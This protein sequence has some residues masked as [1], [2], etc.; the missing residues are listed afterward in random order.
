MRIFF[1]VVA[2]L[3]LGCGSS[4]AQMSTVG[5]TAM[6]LPTTPGAIV[7]S[8]FAG[9]SPF[10]SLFSAATV[11]GAPATTLAAP[12]L[13]D[14]PTLPGTSV[15]CSPATQELSP[16]V[17]SVNSTTTAVTASPATTLNS[18]A[19]PLMP[20][21]MTA[22][23]SSSTTAPILLP[24]AMPVAILGSVRGSS[25]GTI[26]TASSPG[27]FASGGSCTSAPGNALASAS[28]LAPTTPDIPAIPPA[29]A[30]QSP[31][32]DIGSTSISQAAMV[33]PTPNSAACNEAVSMNLANPT[34][35]APVNA[36]AAAPPAGA[37]Q[38]P[39]C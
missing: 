26:T 19:A 37:P 10:T 16:S 27:D 24:P 22:P 4:F 35:M 18:T 39:G 33:M 13:A 2:M 15:N 30:I 1:L 5:T 28:T 21:A 38:A 14:D 23:M 7:S 31:L 25:T 9:P 12:P 6:A 8:P 32:P 36:T 34:M 29:G 17:M 11:P 20:G 3:G